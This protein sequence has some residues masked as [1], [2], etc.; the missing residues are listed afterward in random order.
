MNINNP[1]LAINGG[2]P[3]TKNLIP[4]HKPYLKEDDFKAVEDAIRTTFVSGDGP[5][6]ESLKSNWQIT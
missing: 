2:N 3:I 6:V 5:Y 1:K 4:I